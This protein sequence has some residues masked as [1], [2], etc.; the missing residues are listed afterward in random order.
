MSSLFLSHPYVIVFEF[1]IG[2]REPAEILKTRDYHLAHHIFDWIAQRERDNYDEYG[3]G[4]WEWTLSLYHPE[5][6]DQ[7]EELTFVVES[8]VGKPVF[9]YSVVSTAMRR[10]FL[11]LRELEGLDD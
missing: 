7:F 1:E 8:M 4:R 9:T 11:S 5:P 10:R 6:P 3:S 2:A